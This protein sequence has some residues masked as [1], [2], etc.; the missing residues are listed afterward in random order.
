MPENCAKHGIPDVSDRTTHF[1]FRFFRRVSKFFGVKQCLS[2]SR[3]PES[4]GQTERAN[5]TL[6]DMLRKC[7]SHFVSRNDW[8]VL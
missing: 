4:D 5:H 8:D 1:T 7:V 3:H 2:S 6:E